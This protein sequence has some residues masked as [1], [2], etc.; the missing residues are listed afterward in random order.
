MYAD[1]IRVTQVLQNLIGN[2]VKFT[3]R[4]GK[5]G[6][7]VCVS[8]LGQ[9]SAIC[10]EIADTGIGLSQKQMGLLFRPFKQGDDSTTRHFGGAGLGLAISKKLAELLGGEITVWSRGLKAENDTSEGWSTIFRFVVPWRLVHSPP[11]E[12]RV[13]PGSTVNGAEI[14]SPRSSVTTESM[15]GSPARS[16][17]VVPEPPM[18]PSIVSPKSPSVVSPNPSVT[19]DEKKR[20]A[21]FH[22]LVVDDNVVNQKVLVSLLKRKG[23][24]SVTVAGNGQLA[25]D[26]INQSKD[27]NYFPVILMDCEM[28]VCD[29]FTATQR[30]RQMNCQSTIIALTASATAE[31]RERCAKAGMDLY[32]VKPI[33]I[34]S[35]M[36]TFAQLQSNDVVH[37]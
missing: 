28:P 10:F 16:T 18:S 29:G 11:S 37:V 33:N 27:M 8:K 19:D 13:I 4:N 20:P 7:R 25:I 3:P 5:I 9:E 15:L 32:H 2:A 34:D 35:L 17:R 31:N 26:V 21:Q 24:S 22:I 12:L 14:L 36:S 30:L 23:Y 1:P 6:L